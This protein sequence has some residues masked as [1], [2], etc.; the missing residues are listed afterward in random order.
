MEKPVIKVFDP[1]KEVTLTTDASEHAVS[2]ILSQD[3]HPIM[4][5][6]RRLT[7]AELNYSNIEKE[8]LAIVWSTQRARQF[9]LGRKFL[10]KSDHRPLEFIFNPRK[11]LP[12]VTSARLMR[13][14]I[15][16]M[17][18]DFD[19]MYVKGNTIP[20]VDALSRLA[21]NKEDDEISDTE[22][23][24][25]WV[26]TDVLPIKQLQEETLLDPILS[27][28]SNRIRR[29]KW[30]DCSKAE[31]PYKEVKHK[32]TMDRGVVCNGDLV[33]PPQKM[34]KEIIKSVHDDIHCGIAATQK[35]LKLESWW[36]GYS[37]DIEDY[38]KNVPNAWKSKIFHK[39]RLIHGQRNKNHGV[40]YTWTMPMSRA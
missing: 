12:K 5:L 30:N 35:R 36:P 31:R 7:K 18:F 33:V 21:F 4:Y 15:L 27:K 16:L 40:E 24:L 38:I 14:A 1:R 23:V 37:R 32:L 39:N 28:I 9:L 25:H 29:N 34:R 3:D 13:W 19:I 6:S 17:A 22:D 10:L 11:E 8:A 20:H 2:A 26:E